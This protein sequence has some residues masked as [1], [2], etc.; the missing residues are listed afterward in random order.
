M[1]EPLYQHVRRTQWGLAILAHERGDRRGYQFEDGKLRV[2]ARGYWDLL[3]EVDKNPG[4][5]A[6]IVDELRGRLDISH[7][8]A[9][10]AAASDK[11]QFTLND[12]I[13]VF[14][15]LFPE[16]FKSEGWLADVR[17]VG[18]TR[19]LKRHRQH[20][21]EK[22]QG[23]SEEA[24]TQLIDTGDFGGVHAEIVSLMSGTDLA[25]KSEDL[26]PVEGMEPEGHEALARGLHGVLY[27]EGPD[28]DRWR[29]WLSALPTK[30]W[31]AVTC[32]PG[33][34]APEREIVVK[35]SAAR[36]QAK[37]MAPR[38]KVDKTADA[39]T[40]LRLREMAGRVKQQLVAREL[41]PA[42]M[43]DVYEFMWRTLRPGAR[44]ILNT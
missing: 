1:T 17:G 20:S 10:S 2:F 34:V 43:I 42:D 4:D 8:R 7:A 15:K 14:G 19:Q 9:E 22:A 6:R 13:K 12:Q 11:K 32:V 33:L 25:R 26:A 16:G 44:A 29:A 5:T 21:L 40:Y 3:V 23:L 35:P 24:L 36:S 28:R 39:D 30:S 37:W 27:G 41:E 38:L 31:G 18:Q